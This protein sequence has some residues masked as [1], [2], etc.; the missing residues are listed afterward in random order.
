[1]YLCQQNCDSVL[2]EVAEKSDGRSIRRSLNKTGRYVR[3][4]KDDPQ[5]QALMETHGVGYSSSGL[6]AQMREENNF[7]KQGEVTLKLAKAYGYCW[8]VERA[9]RMAYEAKNAFPDKQLYITNEII[10]NPEVNQVSC[11][12]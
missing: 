12:C 4:P 5:S 11:L 7:W 1:M 6:V 10:H 2:A 3:Q 9:V 8:G